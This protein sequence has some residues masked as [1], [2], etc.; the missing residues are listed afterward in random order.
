MDGSPI[1]HRF[2]SLTALMNNSNN[3][4]AHTTAISINSNATIRCSSALGLEAMIARGILEWLFPCA[5]DGSKQIESLETF[6]PLTANP[7][8]DYGEQ[9]TPLL[10]SSQLF[11]LISLSSQT[12][13]QS[14]PPI[15]VPARSSSFSNQKAQAPAP[16]SAQHDNTLCHVTLE[17]SNWNRQGCLA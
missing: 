12:D 15:S 3:V 11:L 16:L 9:L 6:A 4:R 8:L 1:L 7:K 14:S 10:L 5:G 17:G 13:S 2:D